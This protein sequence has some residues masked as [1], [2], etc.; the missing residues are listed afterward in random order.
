MLSFVE[1]PSFGQKHLVTWMEARGYGCCVL[2]KYRE[3]NCKLGI[4]E[5]VKATL[6]NDMMRLQ[7]YKVMLKNFDGRVCLL[8]PQ[9]DR[10]RYLNHR[11]PLT[12]KSEAFRVVSNP[13]GSQ[14]FVVDEQ[15]L[16][17]FNLGQSFEVENQRQLKPMRH[18][19]CYF[20]C[21]FLPNFRSDKIVIAGGMSN[22][23]QTGRCEIYS[24]SEDEWG[25]LP[26]LGE[27]KEDCSLCLV[28]NH[29]LFCFGGVIDDGY[30]NLIEMLD[31]RARQ[32]WITLAIKLPEK[33]YQVG[34]VPISDSAILLLGESLGQDVYLFQ[35]S[36]DCQTN[37]GDDFDQKK[38]TEAMSLTH[39][40]SA[41]RINYDLF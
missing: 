14:V 33:S 12:I 20:G 18:A 13:E 40:H 22:G 29:F 4:V 38:E 5:L 1:Q 31:L 15:H 39:L 41:S 8:M 16:L 35:A 19:R 26:E 21:L 24:I 25:D 7:S 9:H 28:R 34:C 27:A 17:T 3:Q 11:L 23:E 10:W 36:I 2:D 37:P 30:S 6:E 32:T